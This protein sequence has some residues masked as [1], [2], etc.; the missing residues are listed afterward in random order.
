M[1]EAWCG[2]Q[3]QSIG[4]ARR[5]PGTPQKIA[6][7]ATLPLRLTKRLMGEHK[8]GTNHL[9]WQRQ[10]ALKQSTV[11]D[12][13]SATAEGDCFRAEAARLLELTEP[14]VIEE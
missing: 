5:E 3:W 6:D 14:T 7:A 9:L 10:L 4:G 8:N 2:A 11:L 1:G 13:V 12:F